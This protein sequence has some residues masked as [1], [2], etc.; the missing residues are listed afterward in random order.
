MINI[1]PKL[2]GSHVWKFSHYLTKAYPN[3]PSMA[4]MNNY[5]TYFLLLKNILPCQKCRENYK[6]E[7]KEHPLSDEI[8]GN[9]Q[10][11]INWLINLHNRVNVKTGK[12][13]YQP[14]RHGSNGMIII[15]ILAILLMI[16]AKST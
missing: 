16:K 12:P 2:W 7:L 3:N 14:G 9:K 4:D 15:I 5:K 8:L 1:D 10:L 11:L 6:M 13:I